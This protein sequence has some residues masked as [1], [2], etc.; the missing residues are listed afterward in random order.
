MKKILIGVLSAIL[1]LACT[2]REDIDILPD[3]GNKIYASIVD[4]ESKVE[5]N[6]QKKSV[7]TENDEIMVYTPNQTASYR[8]DGKTGDR[9]GS[10]TII[11][12]YTPVLKSLTKAY[13]LYPLSASEGYNLSSDFYLFSSIQQSQ[14]YKE[15]S[16]GVGV[17]TMVGTSNDEENYSFINTLG[18]LRLSLTGDKIVSSIVFTGND[19]EYTSGD[20]YFPADNPDNWNWTY[21]GERYQQTVL[22]CGE[23]GVQLSADAKVFYIGLPPM[24][25]SNGITVTINFKDGSVYP[26]STTKSVT[27]TRSHVLPMSTISTSD[28]QWQIAKIIHSGAS[29]VS[30]VI[31]GETSMSGTINYGDGNVYYIGG[32]YIHE[33]SDPNSPHTITVQVKDANAIGMSSCKGVTEIDLKNF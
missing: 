29:V 3:D 17:N 8:F 15:N 18:Y 16:F 12:N 10:F 9:S 13:A 28:T 30:P 31:S 19:G 14:V 5:L 32:E 21:N 27:I 25:F 20:W 6:D 11:S 7:W 24:T 23:S 26:Q 22:D 1:I 33:Y 2:K 4:V